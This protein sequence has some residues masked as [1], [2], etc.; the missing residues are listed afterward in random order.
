MEPLVLHDGVAVHLTRGIL[1]GWSVI[2]A[3]LG[4]RTR[5]R[6]RTFSDP[7]YPIVVA[8]S[9]VSIVGGFRLAR[10]HVGQFDG[11]WWAVG[12]G[13]G[14]LVSGVA[15]RV[16][17]ILTL[18][19]FFTYRVTIQEGHHVVERGPYRI[20][21]HPGYTGADLACLGLGIALSNWLS[22]ALLVLL[23]L[24]S[25][26]IRIRVEERQLLDALGDEYRRYAERH[27]RLVPLVW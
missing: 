14:V 11:D 18:G 21:R 27:A 9:I 6:T 1:I 19:R 3:V 22:I 10:V 17:A 20:V 15:F 5:K 24:A 8:A 4:F 16:W 13:L 25:N 2:E 23:P 12:V 26:V 7:T